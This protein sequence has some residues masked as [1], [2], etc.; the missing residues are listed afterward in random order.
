MLLLLACG[1]LRHLYVLGYVLGHLYKIRRTGGRERVAW[2]K[3]EAPKEAV[4]GE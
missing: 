2:R 3:G 1:Y 4:R